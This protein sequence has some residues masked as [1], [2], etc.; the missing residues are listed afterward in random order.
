METKSTKKEIAWA[1][2]EY[3]GDVP[4]AEM[5]SCLK[6]AYGW[7]NYNDETLF[8]FLVSEVYEDIYCKA[9]DC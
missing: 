3:R 4:A 9:Y 7:R 5:F 8:D 2:R 1:W 6:T